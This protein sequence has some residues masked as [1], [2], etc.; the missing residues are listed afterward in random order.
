MSKRVFSGPRPGKLRTQVLIGVLVITLGALAVFDV[1]AV[2][3]LRAYLLDQTDVTL[4]SALSSTRPQLPV[5]LPAYRGQRRA[6]APP[7][8]GAYYIAFV[9]ARGKVVDLQGRPG[10]KLAELAELA[11]AGVHRTV[12]VRR[13]AG[14]ATA[15]AGFVQYRLSSVAVPAF[16]GTLVAGTDLK[17]VD[18]TVD[19]VRLIVAA[20]SG[21]VAV[22]IFLGVGLVMR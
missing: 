8:F 6:P 13:E 21:A 7:V 3:A 9:P 20:G 10:V 2:T 15:S 12:P 14:A 16:S 4:Q 1:A 18:A 22:L 11:A 5:L 19:R 17:A